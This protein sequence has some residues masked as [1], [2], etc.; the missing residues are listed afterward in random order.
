MQVTRRD[1]LKDIAFAAALVGL[2]SWVNQLDEP[3]PMEMMN[4]SAGAY[5]WPWRAPSE[6]GLASPVVTALNRIS[7]GPRPG[8]FERVQAMGIDAYIDEQLHPE[9][10]DDGA[11]EQRIAAAYPTLAMS[12]ADLIQ[13]YPQPKK[14]ANNQN[15]APQP[16]ALAGALGLTPGT[17]TP[18]QVVAELQEATMMRAVH[19]S[20]Q[21][22]QVLVDF[23]S[24]HF[25]IYA[26]KNADRWLKT[27]D[28][29]DVIRK[30]AF[31]KFKD[32]VQAS[33]SSPAMIEY[34]DNRENVKGNANENYAREIMELHTLGV[35]GGYTQKDVQELARAFTGW[36]IQGPQRAGLFGRAG[37][38]EEG[39]FLF[40]PNQHDGGAKRVLGVDL[41]AN[42]GINDA[43]K[44]IDV[45]AHHPSTAKF[46][47]TKLVRHFVSD[48][49]PDALVQRAAQTFTQSDGDIR[50]VLGTILHSDEFKNS[51]AQKIKRPLDLIVSALR[52]VDA[53]LDDT[54]TIAMALRLL[55]QGLYQHLTPDGYPDYGTAWINTSGL[56]GRWNYALLIAANKVPRGQIDLKAA[57]NGAT[58][59]TV[60][61]AVDFWVGYLLHRSIPDADRQKL[62]NALGASASAAFDATRA[63][64]LVAL[65]LASPHFQYR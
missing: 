22:E 55:G 9:T 10:L 24:D 33:A 32:L 14:V 34:L 16:N 50:A 56:L 60:G 11:L 19:S 21:L 35:D 45:L 63:P 26:N 12:A 36:T 13:N 17:R 1:F 4:I 59:R 64:M 61:D 46:I 43:R 31:G 8:D 25:N 65:I 37:Q 23:W 20:H 62:V 51:F 54:R 6:L 38:G 28:D 15:A 48:T 7:F 30:Y 29:R 52:A 44:I 40:N 42:G 5:P 57:T 27:V 58:L 39:T 49:P 3:P 18:Q 53:Q 47:S 41:P 2:P